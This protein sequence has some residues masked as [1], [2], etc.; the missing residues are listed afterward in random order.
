[1][2]FE[3]ASSRCGAYIT[4]IYVHEEY[5]CAHLAVLSCV[6]LP[7]VTHSHRSSLALPPAAE[8]RATPAEC[9]TSSYSD[10]PRGFELADGV[11]D[12]PGSLPQL[13][14]AA[15]SE[16]WGSGGGDLRL[17]FTSVDVMARPESTFL[18]GCASAAFSCMSLLGMFGCTVCLLC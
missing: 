6:L 9:E 8:S 11:L 1:V 13:H 18:G 3:C 12:L 14:A 4:I 5:K 2:S 17:P 10:T 7:W 15:A 16:R